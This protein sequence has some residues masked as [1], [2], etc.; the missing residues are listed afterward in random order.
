[1]TFPLEV[2]RRF[3]LGD[4]VALPVAVPGG[5]S[6]ELW[7]LTTGE[8]DFAVKRMVV[9]ADRPDFVAD[10]EG[11]FAIEQRAWRAGV[12][13]PQ[14]IS[15]RATGRALARVDGDL[16]RVH[17]WVE[18]RPGRPLPREAAA[19][20]ASIH[21]AGSPR[22]AR[23]PDTTWSPREAELRE[24]CE[25]VGS[26]PAELT[27]V[28]SH[29]DLDPKNTIRAG[30]LLAVDWDAAGPTSAVHEAVG[31]A[32]DWTTT[33][34]EFAGTVRAYAARG[35]VDVPAEPWIFAGWVAAQGGWLDY[36]ER[37]RAET[38]L[39]RAEAATTRGRLHTLAAGIDGLLSALRSTPPAP[40]AGPEAAH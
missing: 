26:G 11:S 27:I 12:P 9:N 13:M 25:R 22:V 18:A 4:P 2:A 16:F 40:P 3:A 35:G 36:N 14:P 15:D 7:R 30:V 29:R 33:A 1:M 34:E 31:V 21:A 37:H 6:N 19:L 17:R 5:L 28:D 23:S 10:V 8:G 20:L 39:G 32:L 38:P 24:L